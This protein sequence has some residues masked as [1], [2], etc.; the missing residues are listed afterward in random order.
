MYPLNIKCFISSNNLHFHVQDG[1]YSSLTIYS[2]M[3]SVT[4]KN[5]LNHPLPASVGSVTIKQKNSRVVLIGDM[6]K[7]NVVQSDGE[8]FRVEIVRIDDEVTGFLG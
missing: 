6:F 7:L 3:S 1:T 4:L 2:G 5:K 8:G